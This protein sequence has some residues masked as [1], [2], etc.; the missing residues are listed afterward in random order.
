MEQDR[1]AGCSARAGGEV[2]D[3]DAMLQGEEDDLHARMIEG[4][5]EELAPELRPPL[6]NGDGGYNGDL[7]WPSVSEDVVG[8]GGAL[9]QDQDTCLGLW[10]F[11]IGEAEGEAWTP[12]SAIVGEVEAWKGSFA[13]VKDC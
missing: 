13:A 3:V 8:D 2:V 10:E 9:A 11:R 1:G 12:D 4:G 7:S 5:E 6:A